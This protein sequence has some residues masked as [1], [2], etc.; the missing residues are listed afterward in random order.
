MAGNARASLARHR[1]FGGVDGSV[2]AT[3]ASGSATSLKILA[4]NYYLEKYMKYLMV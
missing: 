1:R 4:M 3:V 2:D